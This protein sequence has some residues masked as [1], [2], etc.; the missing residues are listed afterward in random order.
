LQRTR[1][2]R[3]TNRPY[4]IDKMPNNWLHVGF[5]QTILPQARIIDVRRHPLDCCFSN[6]KQHFARGQAFTYDLGDLGRCYRDYVQLMEHF[7]TV[8]PGRVHRIH[9]ERL[10]GDFE[11]VVRGLL[12]YCGLPFDEACL[13][14]NENQRAVRTASSEQVRQPLYTQGIGSWRPYQAWLE[15][16]EAALGDALP[17][18]P[19]QIR[20]SANHNDMNE[21]QRNS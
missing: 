7:E 13:R 18:Y 4:F 12:E 20:E 16:L 10:V 14:F 15:P 5:I 8:A 9:Y 6:F 3:K 2:Q 21:A 1:V 19:I 17:S 11:P